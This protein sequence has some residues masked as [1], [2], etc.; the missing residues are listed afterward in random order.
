MNT[1]IPSRLLKLALIS[2]A[3][4]SGAVALLQLLAAAELSKWLNLPQSLLVETGMF[5]VAYTGV[6]VYL[7]RS[8]TVWSPIMWLVVIGNV[9]WAIACIT[10]LAERIVSPNLFGAMFVLVQAVAVLIFA[11]LEYAGLRASDSVATSTTSG[12]H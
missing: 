2:D 9:G 6:L 8:A 4:V 7:A 5:L 12:A 10:I 1:I 3:V 11:A